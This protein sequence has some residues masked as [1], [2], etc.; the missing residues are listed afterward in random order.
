MEQIVNGKCDTIGD[1]HA[2]FYI[3]HLHLAV[4]RY[5]WWS[6]VADDDK[7]LNSLP[8]IPIFL[9]RTASYFLERQSR[10][11]VTGM[12]YIEDFPN[13]TV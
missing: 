4:C 3:S 7:L 12:H 6:Y 8:K 11:R 13:K 1:L 9:H 2:C 5:V 10:Q